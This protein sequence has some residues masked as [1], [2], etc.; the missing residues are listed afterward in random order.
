[1]PFEYCMAFWKRIGEPCSVFVLVGFTL[2]EACWSRW[3]S[4]TFVTL[5]ITWISCILRHLHGMCRGQPL[6]VLYDMLKE[7]WSILLSLG[8]T[9]LQ[10][11]WSWLISQKCHFLYNLDLLYIE[12]LAWLGYILIKREDMFLSK[13]FW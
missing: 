7:N 4:L 12:R 6:W 11:C 10:A 5:F 2:L 8:F 1:M 3:T 9:T 13:S